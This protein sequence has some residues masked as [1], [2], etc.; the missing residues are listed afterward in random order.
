MEKMGV[1]V[2]T[3]TDRNKGDGKVL[4]Q[5]VFYCDEHYIDEQLGEES[6]SAYGLQSAIQGNQ[7]RNSRKNLEAETKA[8]TQRSM[9]F[10][11]LLTM[12][13]S[14]LSHTTWDSLPRVG[15]T[16][17]ELGPSTSITNQENAL[18]VNLRE[19]FS[20]L[21]FFLDNSNFHQVDNKTKQMTTTI[22]TT[23]E[24]KQMTTTT[25]KQN[26]GN[27]TTTKNKNQPRLH[28]P[29]RKTRLVCKCLN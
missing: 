14:M 7:S 19:A 8:E 5:L 27:S 1:E 21:R 18:Q 6:L 20:L 17:N 29:F 25:T 2:I 22:T 11:G 16:P 24:S 26:N 9:L 23:K 28:S 3:G 10:T 4:S 15:T 13:C 12:T